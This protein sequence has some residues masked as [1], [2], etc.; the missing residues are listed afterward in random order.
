M[1]WGNEYQSL[2]SR[3]QRQLVDWLLKQGVTHIV[4]SHPH[5]IQPMELRTDTLTGMQHAVV[6]SLGN[7]ISNMSKVNTDGGLIFTLELEKIQLFPPHQVSILVIAD[8]I[9]YG[10]HGL[11]LPKKKLCPL[12]DRFHIR[13]KAAGSST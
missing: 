5:V 4:G 11:P 6:Y 8:I 1:H 9:W 7:F 2:P 3:E 12:S 13:F 10:Q